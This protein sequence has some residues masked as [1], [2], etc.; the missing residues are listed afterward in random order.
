MNVSCD[1]PAGRKVCGFLSHN[2]CSKCFKSFST[3][4]FGVM[5]YSGFNRNSWKVR[6]N[7]EHRKSVDITLKAKTK[8]EKG[9]LE[10]SHGCRF[11]V[12]LDLTYFD[13][14]SMLIVDP[15][16]NLYLG[17]A[18][19]IFHLIWVKRGIISSTSMEIINDRIASLEIPAH[20]KMSRLPP[21]VEGSKISQLNNG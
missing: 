16:H 18:K 5:D 20:S 19:N 17:T 6:T 15:M 14:A 11:S 13:P 3:G 4:K 9:K 10:S 7:V 2:G 21:C 8:A 12:L 1:L